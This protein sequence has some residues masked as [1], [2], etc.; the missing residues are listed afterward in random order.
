MTI[1]DILLIAFSSV[2]IGGLYLVGRYSKNAG[3][4]DSAKKDNQ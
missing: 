1:P 3:H 4:E 2:A